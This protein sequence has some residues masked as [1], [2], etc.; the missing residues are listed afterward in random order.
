[1]EGVRNREETSSNEASR[2]KVFVI[3]AKKFL[4]RK[5]YMD[6]MLKAHPYPYEY[7]WEGDVETMTE[8]EL[9]RYFSDKELPNGT[10][11]NT[12]SN[13]ASCALKH[14]YAYEKI[15][16]Q[17]L[18]GALILE[19]DA[20]LQKAFDE[21][22]P[23]TMQEYESMYANENVIISYEDTRLRF[24]PRSKREK[25]R[26]LYPGDRDRM[27]GCY[28]INQSAARMI[29]DELRSSK[30]H[31]PIDLY[32]RHLLNQGKLVY[33]WCQPT[34]ASQGSHTGLF[35]STLSPTSQVLKHFV[36]RCKLAYKKFL[37]HMR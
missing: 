11:M 2:W 32:H 9:N 8:V 28:F 7:V 19:D 24:V 23:Q 29:L 12:P 35:I 27:T 25:G 31:L 22:Y 1:M 30:C 34:I 33:L 21:I 20:I 17:N 14:F 6:E 18:S 3:H 37:Y 5:K 13:M 36:W 15:I 26:F 16:A 4:D 10:R